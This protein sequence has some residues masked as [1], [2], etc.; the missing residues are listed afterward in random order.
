MHNSCSS[1]CLTNFTIPLAG[2]RIGTFTTRI[3]IHRS[4]CT[5]GPACTVNAVR[6]T[7]GWFTL[8]RKKGKKMINGENKTNQ[9]EQRQMTRNP[10]RF[11]KSITNSG[12]L[13]FLS[14]LE[15]KIIL[16]PTHNDLVLQCCVTLLPTGNVL[17]RTKWGLVNTSVCIVHILKIRLGYLL[18]GINQKLHTNLYFSIDVIDNFFVYEIKDAHS[19]PDL[20][21]N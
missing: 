10:P 21:V 15:S 3:R 19:L 17:T 7:F 6:L 16:N 14:A 13:V 5:I 8:G 9:V 1:P 18:N 2:F 12:E 4:D 20:N 11:E